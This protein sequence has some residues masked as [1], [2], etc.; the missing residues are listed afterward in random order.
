MSKTKISNVNSAAFMRA[1]E[2]G[3]TDDIDEDLVE[4]AK[5]WQIRPGFWGMDEEKGLTQMIQKGSESEIYFDT[6]TSI[7]IKGYF[8]RFLKR[9]DLMEKYKRFKR[10]YLLHSPPGVGKSAL[11]R[12]FCHSIPKE[13]RREIAVIRMSGQIPWRHLTWMFRMPYRTSVKA[14][15]LIIEDLGMKQHEGG[16]QNVYESVLLNFLDGDAD[17]FRVPTM[18]LV[19]TNFPRDL[20]PALTDRPGRFNQIIAV[21]P[22][23]DEETFMLIEKIGDMKLTDEQK[24]IFRG[25]RLNPDHIIEIL[26]RSELEEMSLRESF[27]SVLLEREGIVNMSHFYNE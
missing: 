9:R 10:A 24:N 14:I 21:E 19:T 5:K 20:G 11:I 7:R 17:L 2:L 6:A 8:D 23:T 15:I 12:N 16:Q 27:E 26:M 4:F 3:Q 1:I 22:P 13:K 25:N 18:I